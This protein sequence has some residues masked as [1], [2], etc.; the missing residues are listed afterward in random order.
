M[1]LI[2]NGIFV[3]DYIAHYIYC[4][5]TAYSIQH[6]RMQATNTPNSIE[7]NGHVRG[8]TFDGHDYS[9][10]LRVIIVINR[11]QMKNE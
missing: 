3:V 4:V 5:H 7:P 11:I 10:I 6:K 9:K 8:S 1:K 2:K